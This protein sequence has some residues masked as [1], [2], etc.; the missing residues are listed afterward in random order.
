MP[1]FVVVVVVFWLLYYR[2]SVTYRM[3]RNQRAGLRDSFQMTAVVVAVMFSSL[4]RESVTH[5]MERNTP[6]AG[7]QDNF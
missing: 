1:T 2:E 7:L 3:E 5:R 6:R 4:Y